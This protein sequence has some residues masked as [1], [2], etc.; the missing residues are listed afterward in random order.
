VREAARQAITMMG[1]VAH[2]Q[3]R[4]SYEDLVGKKPPRD[5]TWDRTARELFGELDRQRL[6]RVYALFDEGAKAR[7]EGKLDAM[8]EAWDKLLARSPLF[9]HRGEMAGGYLELANKKQDED[10]PAALAA[11]RRAERLATDDRERSRAK[12]LALTLEGE[13]LAAEGVADQVL[14]H[15]ALELD[16][17]NQRAKDALARLERGEIAR[18]SAF[19]R[20]AAACAIGLSALIALVLIGTRR[21]KRESEARPEGLDPAEH[22]SDDTSRMPSEL[23]DEREIELER[24][25]D[26]DPVEGE[27]PAKDTTSDESRNDDD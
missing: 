2:W 22:E 26:A 1:E 13:Q 3:L 4:D 23:R 14:F 15:R 18:Q 5:W 10:R 9:E 17:Q 16:P 11:A 8:R 7:S 27:R 21:G 12:S 6:A 20:Y 24:R 19:G 25:A